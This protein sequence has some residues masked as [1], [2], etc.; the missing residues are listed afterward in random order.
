MQSDTVY[1]RLHR[2]TCKNQYAVQ[3]NTHRHASQ[4]SVHCDEINE[5]VDRQQSSD[6]IPI[7]MS[8]C[9]VKPSLNLIHA[10]NYSEFIHK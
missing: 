10:E 8:V 1:T 2:Y 4:L 6:N 5:H 7:S 3:R 9:N